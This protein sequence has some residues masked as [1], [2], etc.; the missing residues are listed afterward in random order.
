M[1]L[2]GLEG[3]NKKFAAFVHLLSLPYTA[4]ISVVSRQKIVIGGEKEE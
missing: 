4:L 2:V 3:L 1:L